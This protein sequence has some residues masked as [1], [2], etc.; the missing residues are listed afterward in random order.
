M[1]GLPMLLG[2]LNIFAYICAEIESAPN[3]YMLLMSARGLL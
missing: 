2:G 3:M 1:K